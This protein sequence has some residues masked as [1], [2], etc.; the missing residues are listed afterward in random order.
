MTAGCWRPPPTTPPAGVPPRLGLARLAGARTDR[1][2]ARD[3][4]GPRACSSAPTSARRPPPRSTKR[5]AAAPAKPVCGARRSS[6]PAA[7]GHGPRA[8]DAAEAR[9]PRRR[10]AADTAAAPVPPRPWITLMVGVN[11]SG[12]TTTAAKLAARGAMA[13]HRVLL[14]AADTFRAAA[15]DPAGGVGR[16]RRRRRHPPRHARRDPS[17]V[18]FAD[19]LRSQAARR[20]DL[21]I[22]DTAGRL[23]TQHNLMQELAKVVSVVRREMPG[24]PHETL[25]VLDAT[26]GQNGLAQA[27]HF[28]SAAPVTG[29]VLA[30]LD[31]SAKG[32]VAFPIR[33]ELG[34][35][36][37]YIGTGEGLADLAPF[38]AAAYVDGLLGRDG[39]SER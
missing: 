15:I 20:A 31:G 5:S 25:L 35:P 12:K 18:V 21:V 37:A 27:R 30:K 16:A 26:T 3:V 6:A 32:G 8:G 1:H 28:L 11:G 29:L 33:R 7:T 22:I 10:L 13:G 2:H 9:P 19:A 38:D 17:A 36:I 34:L 24:A 14:V 4:G 39:N 23:H